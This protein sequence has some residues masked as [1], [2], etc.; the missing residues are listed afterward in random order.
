MN[1][2]IIGL[3]TI[4][5]TVL[6]NLTE[7]GHAITIIDEDKDIIES[8]I[9]K[10][11]VFGVVGNGA[12]MD[13]QRE[14]NVEDADLVVA[15]TK[16]DE[17]NIFA[18]LAAKHLGVSETIAR[19]RNPAYRKQ[20]ADMKDDLGISMI[21][22]PE[23]ETANEIFNMVNLP[24]AVRIE[25]FAKGKAL[26][27]E[28]IAERGC[29][30]IGESLLS[31]GRKLKSR[32]L[33]CAVQRGDSVYIPSGNFVIEEGDKIH[34]TS[35]TR[36]LTDFL[37]E[38]NLAKMPLRN[39]MV[40]GGGKTGFYLADALSDKE[41]AVKLIEANVE[42][43]DELAETLPGVTV[44]C[45]NGT[46]HDL[47]LEEGLEA[48]D[49][50]VALTDVDEE[51]IIVSMFAKKKHV[52]K[53][54]TQIENDDLYGMLDELGIE[55][56]VSPKQVVAGRIISFVRALENSKGSNVLTL[57][58]LVNNRVEALEFSARTHES[59]YNIPLKDL[60]IKK[61]C[62]IACI[63]RKNEVI[64]PNGSSAI[65]FGDH[66]VVVTTHKNFDDLSDVFE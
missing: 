8:L 32:F 39:I 53:T 34:F 63:I 57:Y 20:I 16:N 45:G 11:D 26:L 49:S 35:A 42:K 60:N 9:E 51:N 22:N 1:I 66:V 5:D 7:E 15:L 64:I 59:F 38:V 43:A 10:Y 31:L 58:R 18:C 4:G 6:R 23:L 52:K 50:F 40:V 13:I 41:Y 48:M 46:Q 25:R 55:N 44:I 29:P 61:N 37:T 47:L 28:V 12:C 17:L 24:S 14:A 2:V 30:L 65:M 27:V 19:V 54:I 3:G 62:L 21:V 56:S 33:I 36:N